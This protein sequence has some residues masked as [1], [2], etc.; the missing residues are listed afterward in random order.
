M[1]IEQLFTGDQ[2]EMELKSKDFTIAY[3][4]ERSA[5]LS[6]LGQAEFHRDCETYFMVRDRLQFDPA[7]VDLQKRCHSCSER[8]HETLHCPL[9]SYVANRKVLVKKFQRCM[10]QER[11]ITFR[12][13]RSKHQPL[14]HLKY[15]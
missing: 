15:I 10:P 6:V 4:L 12:R 1:G 13:A 8:S 7:S 5:F 3:C 11:R 14:Q 2:L 9:L